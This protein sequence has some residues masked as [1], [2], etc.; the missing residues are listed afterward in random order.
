MRSII[1]AAAAGLVLT[2]HAGPALA[3]AQKTSEAFAQASCRDVCFGKP[4]AAVCQMRCERM[5]AGKAKGKGKAK[6]K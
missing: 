5:R 1:I 2:A 6:A 3:Q 4:Q